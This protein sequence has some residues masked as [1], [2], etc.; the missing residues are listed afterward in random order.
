MK[1]VF[2]NVVL[3]FSLLSLASISQ[4][5]WSRPVWPINKAIASALAEGKLRDL[6]TATP[7]GYTAKSGGAGCIFNESGPPITSVTVAT[8]RDATGFPLYQVAIVW[9]GGYGWIT[10]L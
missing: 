9:F 10:K 7:T 2:V 8:A 1:K 6:V 3:A 5:A 4:V